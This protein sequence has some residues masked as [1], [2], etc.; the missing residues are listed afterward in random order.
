VGKKLNI[1]NLAEIG[2][3]LSASPV[4]RKFGT[5]TKAQNCIMLPNEGEGA[6]DK[7]GGLAKLNTSGLAG[8]IYGLT[9][10]S[11]QLQTVQR[12]WVAYENTTVAGATWCATTDGTTWVNSSVPAACFKDSR[13]SQ[14]NL[15]NNSGGGALKD[16]MLYP[17][18]NYIIYANAGHG[19]PPVRLCDGAADYL[20]GKV[21]FN[22][23]IQ[24]AA[25]TTPTNVIEVGYVFKYQGQFYFTSLDDSATR[26]GT[27]WSLD[28]FS[29]Q[30]TR[31][32][33]GFAGA[34]F[35]AGTESNRGAP[36]FITGWGD[37][38]WTITNQY[39]G[40]TT[41]AIYRIRPGVD[42]AWVKDVEFAGGSYGMG[43]CT[44]LGYLYATLMWDAGG[45]P[46]AVYRRSAEGTWAAVDTV[47]IAGY[48]GYFRP[49]SF[50]DKIFAFQSNQAGSPVV[51]KIRSSPDGVTWSDDLTDANLNTL[52]GFHADGSEITTTITFKGNQYVI[53]VGDEPSRAGH[54]L[55]RVPGAAPGTWT[56]AK[57]AAA[58]FTGYAAVLT[59]L[60]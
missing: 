44:H 57:S 1:F 8:Q 55:K 41:C 32:G 16:R 9:N 46:K 27:V 4:H 31:I 3:D 42:A 49:F 37:R 60:E 33:N 2:L 12:L 25:G 53:D 59:T 11:Q 19:A 10:V 47:V 40:A 28:P 58:G 7:R 36:W 5:L 29:G 34:T 24:I 15:F 51:T 14:G 43:L 6:V 50:D 13:R 20:F 26:R 48:G 52:I 22:Q 38:L 56:V 54:V 39:A 35:A 30:M 45:S 21:P 23:Q 17:D 18:N